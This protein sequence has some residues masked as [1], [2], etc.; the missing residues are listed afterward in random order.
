MLPRGEG[1]SQA[2]TDNLAKVDQRIARDSA[3]FYATGAG[4]HVF[5]ARDFSLTKRSKRSNY[6]ALRTQRFAT[7]FSIITRAI[8]LW[9]NDSWTPLTL[10]RPRLEMRGY[11]TG[12]GRP[13]WVLRCL[14]FT[15]SAKGTP[16]LL[17]ALPQSPAFIPALSHQSRLCAPVCSVLSASRPYH[18]RGD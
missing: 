3:P 5:D 7:R 18:T 1:P 10:R 16:K 4:L 2:F 13:Q 9:Q 6:A 17:P 12:R 15:C 8:I 11:W 14:G